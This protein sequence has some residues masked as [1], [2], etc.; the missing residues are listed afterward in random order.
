MSG[1][2]KSAPR[3]PFP[4]VRLDVLCGAQTG[5]AFVTRLDYWWSN[6]AAKRGT[7]FGVTARQAARGRRGGCASRDQ[8]SQLDG[9]GVCHPT[10]PRRARTRARSASS[11]AA[12]SRSAMSW[13]PSRC[14][15]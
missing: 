11:H 14:R 8:S 6:C 4:T 3:G 10:S 13:F 7:A 1:A 9:E 15:W 5:M 12:R 2:K